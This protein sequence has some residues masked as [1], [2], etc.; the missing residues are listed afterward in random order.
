MAVTDELAELLTEAWVR[1][2][3]NRNARPRPAGGVRPRTR[4]PSQC[5]RAIGRLGSGAI[6]RARAVLSRIAM[7]DLGEDIVQGAAASTPPAQDPRRPRSRSALP[8]SAVRARRPSQRR[9]CRAGHRGA[10]PT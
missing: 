2:H 7:A 8:P 4:R 5:R 6:R 3:W 9:G 1:A 10:L